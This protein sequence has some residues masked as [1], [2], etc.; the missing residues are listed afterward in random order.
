MSKATAVYVV[1]SSDF[2][3]TGDEFAT[4]D[5]YPGDDEGE[6]TIAYRDMD[7]F[8]SFWSAMKYAERL[9]E[10]LGGVEVVTV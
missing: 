10:K 9:A 7:S 1:D 4:W 8:R 5:V 6:P 3:S 2:D